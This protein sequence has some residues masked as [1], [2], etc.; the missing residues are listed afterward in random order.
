MMLTNVLRLLGAVKTHKEKRGIFCRPAFVL[1]PLSP[2]HGV[3]GGDGL[4]AESKIALEALINKWSSEGWS[5]YLCLAGAVIG[6]TRST[7]LMADNDIVAADL[8]AR[9]D[10]RTFSQDEMAANLTALF[11]PRMVEYAQRDPIWA[12]FSGGFGA[13][14]DLKGVVA[15]VRGDVMAEATRRRRIAKEERLDAQAS[16]FYLPFHVVRIL[17][18]I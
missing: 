5:D 8:E 9:H 7:G 13:V 15:K 18:T 6:W 1:L 12:D 2:N 11:H 10:I 14:P 4:Y 16:L 3:F 17:L